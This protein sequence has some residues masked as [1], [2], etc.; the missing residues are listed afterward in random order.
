VN[1]PEIPLSQAVATYASGLEAEIGLLRQLDALAA[2]QRDADALNDVG[3]L[4]RCTDERTQL[5]AGLVALEHQLKPVRD[6]LAESQLEATRIAGFPALV[7]RHREAAALV[8]RILN[9]DQQTLDALRDAE[10]ARRFAAQT[11][12]AGETTLAAYRRV[13]APPPTHAALIDERG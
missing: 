13:V 5:M 10:Q 6:R 2:R 4:T 9:R 11:I 3:V 1:V 7:A 8:A 12:E